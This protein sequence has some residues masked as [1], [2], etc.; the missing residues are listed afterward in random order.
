[1]FPTFYEFLQNNKN[2]QN[3]QNLQGGNTF[4]KTHCAAI[5]NVKN[6]NDILK[7]TQCSMLKL[8]G[9]HEYFCE[10]HKE[11]ICQDPQNV[12][13]IPNLLKEIKHFIYF[14]P[15]PPIGKNKN[16]EYD[17]FNN[18][19][20]EESENENVQEP[21]IEPENTTQSTT[22][23]QPTTSSNFPT[24]STYY[25]Y[26]FNLVKN[27]DIYKSK[28]VLP[29]ESESESEEEEFVS[30]QTLFSS[31]SNKKSQTKEEE[32]IDKEF[33][34]SIRESL[35]EDLNE[36][37]QEEEQQEQDEEKEQE[38]EQQEVEEEEKA[39]EEEDKVEE[40]RKSKRNVNFKQDKY[41]FIKENLEKSYNHAL[42]LANEYDVQIPKGR[43]GYEKKRAI[44][45]LVANAKYWKGE[46]KAGKE[47]KSPEFNGKKF[48]DA[49]F[50]ALY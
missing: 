11:L 29:E 31:S 23:P 26:T 27:Y 47:F 30:S 33:E 10:H 7:W 28:N 8:N 32:K 43:Q 4:N 22:H 35:G 41:T 44:L 20:N 36:E 16:T 17:S 49:I 9:T 18:D 2:F 12:H 3:L 38:E 19:E 21:V 5:T 39:Y 40:K 50:D 6:E 25:D 34:E 1:M 14:P 42:N 15:F 45:Q 24:L 37:K 13:V 48:N 46:L